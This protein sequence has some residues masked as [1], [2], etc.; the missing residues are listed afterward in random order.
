MQMSYKAESLTGRS[1]LRNKFLT[2][3]LFMLGSFLFSSFL[4]AEGW[5]SP[6]SVSDPEGKWKNEIRCTDGNTGT[7]ADDWSLRKGWG[8]F[9]VLNYNT[10]VTSDRVRVNSDWW[11]GAVDKIDLDVY[12]DGSWVNVHEGAVANC[13]WTTKTFPAGDVTKIRYRFHY[14]KSNYIYWL[15]EI[16]LYEKTPQ[17]QLT[18]NTTV[19]ATSVEPTS[20]I[21]HGILDNDG[22]EPSEYRFVYGT[23]TNY[24]QST[25]WNGPWS[26]GQVFGHIISGLSDETEYHF[27]IQTRNSVGTSAGADMT[28][29][30]GEPVIGWVPPTNYSDPSG[31][32][33]NE[34]NGFDDMQGS[35]ARCYHD[36]WTDQW[37]P[38][39]ILT[40]PELKTTGIRFMA[41]H[42]EFIDQIDVD[43][44]KDGAW[45]GVYTG[46]FGDRQWVE[47][48]FSAGMV[49]QARVR[50]HVTGTNCG[51]Y[52][53]LVEFD[54]LYN[55]AP[56][57]VNETAETD[58]ETEITV[59]VLEND[60]DADGHTIVLSQIVDPAH[61]TATFS[62]DS[63]TY[64]PQASFMGTDT[65]T[66]TVTDQLGAST[67]GTLTIKTGIDDDIYEENDIQA[68]A[69]DLSS[70]ITENSF[71]IEN[72]AV[73]PSDEDWY[74]IQTTADAGLILECLFTYRNDGRDDSDLDLAVFSQDGSVI[75]QSYS[76]T[77][78]EKVA[79]YA[80]AGQPLFIRVLG[81]DN[82][83][84][85]GSGPSWNTYSL[86]LS[87]LPSE[88]IYEQND[89]F[90]AAADITGKLTAGSF[91]SGGLFCGPSDDDWFKVQVTESVT[92][93]INTLFAER[94]DGYDDSDIDL[95]VYNSSYQLLG[96]S[97]SAT[98]NE[99]VEI[100]LTAADTVYVRIYG[101]D[102]TEYGGSKSWN[103][104]TLEVKVQYANTA[105]VADSKNVTTDEDTSAVITLSGT[106]AENDPLTFFVLTQPAHG[107]L[108]GTAPSLT[109]TPAANYNGSDSFTYKVNDGTVDSNTAALSITV[110]PVNDAPTALDDSVSTPLNTAVTVDVLANDTD[111]DGD[112]LSIQSV[113]Q[114]ANG[115]ASTDGANVTFTPATNI[116]GTETITCTITDGKGETAASTL[117]VTVFLQDDAYE[118]NDIQETAADVSSLILNNAFT[119]ENLAV[120][121]SDEDWFKIQTADNTGFIL[122]CLFTQRNDG[123]DDSDLDLAVFAEDGTVIVESYSGSDNEKVAFYTTANQPVFVRVL[124]YDNSEWGGAGPSW[125]TYSL[126]LSE[127]PADDT[128]EENDSFG[129]AK[130][131]TSEMTGGSFDSGVLFCGPSE[132]DWFSA[133]VTEPATVTVNCIFAERGDEYDDS[134]ID[135]EV[136]NSSH[137]LIASSLS[138]TD[139]ESVEF[140]LT[141]ADTIYVKIYGADNTEYGGSKSWNTYT[142]EININYGNTAPVAD[143]ITIT[144]DEDTAAALT[145]SGSDAE[146]DPLTFEVVTQPANGT[147][148]GTAPSLTYTPAANTNGADSFTYRAYDGAQYSAPATVSITVNAVNDAPFGDDLTITLDEDTSA[149]VTLAGTDIDNDPMTYVIVTE[150]QQGTLS[151]TAPE[152]TYTP[153][154]DANGT[155]SFTYK[156]N[157]GS[158]D[159]NT[160]SV[161]IT[162]TPVNDNPAA[163]DDT[164]ST[165]EDVAVTIDVL[166]NDSDA[167]NDTLSVQS[168]TQPVNGT[169][170]NNSTNVSYTPG[171]GFSG[172]DTFT[173]TVSDGNGGTAT[174][175]VS[176]TVND[177]NEAP[178]AQDQTLSTDE[179][180]A[181]TI[182]LS[183]TD[184]D[185]D[186]LTYTVLSNPANGTLSGT[187]PNLTFT[188]AADWS[189]STSFTFKANDGTVDSD[190]AT[191]SIT[192]TAVND[193]PVANGDT[194][195]TDED[196][197]ASFD[198]LANDVDV[199][200]NTL[201]LASL[202]NPPSNGVAA[203][204]AD[205]TRVEYTP[206]ADYYGSD[207]VTYTVSDG[208]GNSNTA[209][210][211]VTVNAVND[212]PVADS[213]DLT[214]DEDTALAV[215]LTASDPDDDTLTFTVL[216]D[217]E[218]G[219]LTGTAPNLT[220]TP[221]ADWNGETSF[222]FKANDGTENS[223][224]ATVTLT[225]TPLQDA[226]VA[227]DDTATT[228]EDTAATISVLANDSDADNDTLS[229]QSV[230]QGSNGTVTNNETDVT[231][232]PNENWSGTDTFTYTASDGNN[233]TDTATVSV[234]VIEQ[235]GA[236]IA[237]AQS[238]TLSEDSETPVDI[239]LTGSDPDGDDITFAIVDAPSHGTLTG[240]A[241]NLTYMPDENYSGTDSFTFKV[242]DGTEDSN[243]VTVSIDVTPINDAPVSCNSSEEVI[244]NKPT[245]ITVSAEDADNDELT[246]VITDQPGH[247]ILTG[248]GP[249]YTYTPDLGY[250]GPD[251]FSFK[252]NDGTED[253]SEAVVSIDVFSLYIVSIQTE[254][255]LLTNKEAV[256]VS[257]TLDTEVVRIEARNETINSKPCI[258]ALH[259]DQSFEVVNIPVEAGVNT[260]RLTTFNENGEENGTTIVNVK[261]DQ[262]PPV[263][264][265]PSYETNNPWAIV[266][267]DNTLCNVIVQTGDAT[268]AP[269]RILIEDAEEIDSDSFYASYYVRNQETGEIIVEPTDLT[270]L[271]DV[272]GGHAEFQ[273]DDGILDNFVTRYLGHE[274]VFEYFASDRA[275]NWGV[276]VASYYPGYE[277]ENFTGLSLDIDNQ[278]AFTL[279]H[280][281]TDDSKGTRLV[282]YASVD[283]AEF[284]SLGNDNWELRGTLSVYVESPIGLK[285][286]ELSIDVSSCGDKANTIT[287]QF[288]GDEQ[289]FF[290]NS[291]YS[292]TKSTLITTDVSYVFNCPVIYPGNDQILD[293]FGINL[294]TNNLYNCTSTLDLKLKITNGNVVYHTFY[295]GFYFDPSQN[296]DYYPPSLFSP[297]DFPEALID[298]F[299][300]RIETYIN[301]SCAGVAYHMGPVIANLQCSVNGQPN[302]MV[303]V[304][305]SVPPEI[306]FYKGNKPSGFPAA[307]AGDYDYYF[308]LNVPFH[309]ADGSY[310]EDDLEFETYGYPPDITWQIIEPFSTNDQNREWYW[311]A[312]YSGFLHDDGKSLVNSYFG[313]YIFNEFKFHDYSIVVNINETKDTVLQAA[314]WVVD[315]EIISERSSN[316]FFDAVCSQVDPTYYNVS[317]TGVRPGIEELIAS[318][319][320]ATGQN[321]EVLVKGVDF[322]SGIPIYRNA[323]IYL[324]TDTGDVLG[325]INPSTYSP[326]PVS[327]KG[328]VFDPV[329]GLSIE[330]KIF[331]DGIQHELNEITGGVYS[332]DIP[333]EVFDGKE[334]IIISYVNSSG[335]TCVLTVDLLF[336]RGNPENKQAGGI[337]VRC[338][339]KI[340]SSTLNQN[341]IGGWKNYR[342][343][344][345][346]PS[347]IIIRNETENSWGN[348]EVSAASEIDFTQG[349]FVVDDI[350]FAV[351]DP[352]INRLDN[353]VATGNPVI[354]GRVGDLISATCD[355][356]TTY[357][358]VRGVDFYEEDIEL[359]VKSVANQVEHDD[360]QSQGYDTSRV[361]VEFVFC[362]KN[363]SSIVCTPPPYYT[364]CL[365]LISEPSDLPEDALWQ[366]Y[367]ASYENTL[368]L[369]ED[370]APS[371]PTNGFIKIYRVYYAH[372]VLPYQYD[373]FYDNYPVKVYDGESD[374]PEFESP[375][376]VSP[377]QG[378]ASPGLDNGAFS[379][380]FNSAP[381]YLHNGAL[382]LGSNDM[383]TSSAKGFGLNI[384][385][386][387]RSHNT[388]Q[389]EFGYGWSLGYN[390]RLELI[391]GEGERQIAF[392]DGT[393]KFHIFTETDDKWTS[394]PGLYLRL[395]AEDDNTFKLIDGGG[396]EY[397]FTP[398]PDR[399]YL[400]TN[401]CD[402][403]GNMLTI[404]YKKKGADFIV[405]EVTDTFGRKLTFEGSPVITRITGPTGRYLEYDYFEIDDDRLLKK[406]TLFSASEEQLSTISYY[407]NNSETAPPDELTAL[408]M[409]KS[410]DNIYW[411]Y[412]YA[413]GKVEDIKVSD[414]PDGS[415]TVYKANTFDYSGPVSY[416]DARNN[417]WQYTINGNIAS[418]VKDPAGNITQ[419]TYTANLE[420]DE[421]TYPLG[422]KTKYYYSTQIEDPDNPGTMIDNPNPVKC[423]N[424]VKV[425][426]TPDSTRGTGGSSETI[427]TTTAYTAAADFPDADADAAE[428]WNFVKSSTDARGY[429]TYNYYNKDGNLIRT[430][431]N[432]ITL[433]DGTKQN[434]VTKYKYNDYGQLLATL[435]A[436]GS[437]SWNEYYDSSDAIGDYADCEG[438]LRRTVQSVGRSYTNINTSAPGNPRNSEDYVVT[439]Y[440]WDSRGN[441]ITQT[442]PKG[443]SWITHYDELS[444]VTDEYSPPWANGERNHTHYDYG[445]TGN[446]ETKTVKIWTPDDQNST[447]YSAQTITTTMTYDP[448]DRLL[449]TTRGDR[450]TTRTYYADGS[451]KS[452]RDPEGVYTTYTYNNR[453]LQE[454][455]ISRDTDNDPATVPTD[456]I[457]S[458]SEFDANGNL[459]D[460][461]ENTTHIEHRDYDGYDRVIKTTDKE[462]DTY[463]ETTFDNNGNVLTTV[464]KKGSDTLSSMAYTYNELND[465]L[466]SKDL[467][468]NST[469]TTDTYYTQAKTAVIDPSGKKTESFVDGLGRTVK[470]VYA[471]G[472]KVVTVYDKNGAV[473]STST[474]EIGAS[475]EV[476]GDGWHTTTFERNA[477]DH[478]TSAT[479]AEGN[480]TRAAT[481][482]FG[483][484]V[485][486]TGPDNKIV[487]KEFNIHGEATA[488][489][490]GYG[491]SDQTT[492]TTVYNKNSQVKSVTQGGQSTTY[493]YANNML[494]RE[495]YPDNTSIEYEYDSRDFLTKKILKDGTYF[496]YDY[497]PATKYLTQIRY[498]NGADTYVARSFSNFDGFGRA[499]TITEYNNPNRSDDD[500]STTRVF[501]S[502]GQVT[503]ESTTVWGQTNTVSRQF[504]ESG[505]MTQITYPSGPVYTYQYTDTHELAK[506][507][508]GQTDILDYEHKGL[509]LISGMK[510]NSDKVNLKFNYDKN[511]A[512]AGAGAI[513]DL[514]N[515]DTYDIGITR[516][517]TG[518]KET[519]TRFGLTDTFDYDSKNRHNV[520]HT[521]RPEIGSD[522]FKLDDVDNLEA[523]VAWLFNGENVQHHFGLANRL[524]QV[525]FPDAPDKTFTLTY[526]GRGNTTED[527]N[528][529]YFWDCFDRVR[530]IE[531]K[532]TTYKHTPLTPI[533]INTTSDDDSTTYE[534]SWT[535]EA[536]V[537][538]VEFE[539]TD[540]AAYEV[541]YLDNENELWIKLTATAINVEGFVHTVDFPGVQTDKIRIIEQNPNPSMTDIKTGFGAWTAWR[542]VQY[543][544]DALGRRV[545]R[546]QGETSDKMLYVYNGYQVI[547]QKNNANTLKKRIVYGAGINEPVMLEIDNS[548]QG[549]DGIYYYQLDDLNSCYVLVDQNGQIVEQY[550]YSST[551]QTVIQEPDGTIK[552]YDHDGETST[553]EVHTVTSDFGNPFMFTSMWR[554]D[555]TGIY[556]THYRE[557]NPAIGRWLT[558][559]PAGYVDGMNLY[560]YY[561]G[562]NG[563]DVLGLAEIMKG[564]WGSLPRTWGE[565]WRNLKEEREKVNKDIRSL[566]GGIG[567]GAKGAVDVVAKTPGAVKYAAKFYY[568]R[569][570][571]GAKEVII[572][573]PEVAKM[574]GKGIA[575]QV[576][577]AA[578]GDPEAIGELLFTAETLL[579][580]Q[581]LSAA[582][583][584]SYSGAIR[585]VSS[586]GK[587]AAVG[588]E[589]LAAGTQ[590][591]I[592]I[593][594][595]VIKAVAVAG[596]GTM[597]TAGTGSGMN[598]MMKGKPGGTNQPI[599]FSDRISTTKL[600]GKSYTSGAKKLRKLGL[601]ERVT[602]TGRREFFDAKKRVRAAWDAKRK[603]VGGSHWHKFA[604][605]GRT[606]LN[607]A[608]HVVL[609][610]MPKAHIPSK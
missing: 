278:N 164:A 107:T 151:G 307:V 260:V 249:V 363:G 572:V 98:D 336:E 149:G 95:E 405:S 346:S 64:T 79:F 81:Y 220:F 506:I 55:H 183:A 46:P 426:Q 156:V 407:Y 586:G 245:D 56:T 584:G 41:K 62:G 188:P 518:L 166:A 147:L 348:D 150:P 105:P 342:S 191:V 362:E 33:E 578:S 402:R 437:M 8:A 163:N 345:D 377:R 427:V 214:T 290:N 466:T 583:L 472:T 251:F 219:T 404:K 228:N 216:T 309:C 205:K 530:R 592:T 313:I 102:N 499:R 528:F 330:R 599:K 174:A 196:T 4:H 193:A 332:F 574:M 217:P 500:T 246:Y 7:Y 448:L 497:D 160:A 142:L 361:Y 498:H 556:H 169:V 483:R 580:G 177:T 24:G 315:E 552:Y 176:V 331:I 269:L 373:I 435:N 325:V 187:A 492:T 152:L 134:D 72:L 316:G 195:S 289:I 97:L 380:S 371:E 284:V 154:P 208:I 170:T 303:E 450:V 512:L 386:T 444:R 305:G 241:P 233:G 158:E 383:S 522:N 306:C 18:Q 422:N 237:D 487:H 479:D 5:K 110:T 569:G 39:L 125:N 130:N 401:I 21:L 15:Y 22:G 143:A 133:D 238:V 145:L 558:P 30:T 489:T 40:R 70:E 328:K 544:Y 571:K 394:P 575:Q 285:S 314:E 155:D 138:A 570:L 493:V 178:V 32:W 185:N 605:D 104:Y 504:S 281:T 419:Y 148:S 423:G 136:Y 47:K 227:A 123:R 545:A 280:Q 567:K 480:T 173:Y 304:C 446:L 10:P 231:Y 610:K 93:T 469:T 573:A 117:S 88:D 378:L 447:T 14:L 44:Y 390:Q 92:V 541:W 298:E 352:D 279:S 203:I 137:Q 194:V 52:W 389:L 171:T 343:A 200:N 77:E 470:T 259:G 582:N 579:A 593:E 461:Y 222:T 329:F 576:K 349:E 106:D 359:K 588:G 344:D 73:R 250:V 442:D 481:D 397:R 266:S 165:D 474:A 587:L 264:T 157:D 604:P 80:T 13:S 502:F 57:V 534:L 549:I 603:S 255:S 459:T 118:E 49:S 412:T 608:G 27:Q 568:K 443:R 425:I 562:V 590:V 526:D 273:P 54:F 116:L 602:K 408:K 45:E 333:V 463:T 414:T 508:S 395:L 112:T 496:L 122:E 258:G 235:Q 100:D 96:S 159:S 144:T 555:I 452:V 488:V 531:N 475:S 12:K 600:K 319:L 324:T 121:P 201:Q 393:G 327:I 431:A 398:V 441:L 153:L 296:I 554:D 597:I 226:P 71:T 232:T 606:P 29:T 209:T 557:Y 254:P 577:A 424:V 511:G 190:P 400:L 247:G 275:G 609:K 591:I 318:S 455:I 438:Y 589:T 175:T 485:F 538:F 206:N 270:Y 413:D 376:G 109:Y 146:N 221:D 242:N 537:N 559:D 335:R 564:D 78:N 124:G 213:Q 111:V 36:L 467:L 168:V 103:N 240:T 379:S 581:G 244:I 236:P 59:N 382:V 60:S 63:I 282:S 514:I 439:D 517:S 476:G 262:T 86:V 268:I 215:T 120:R 140:E 532:N 229:I 263:L 368:P 510:L 252:V 409:I 340:S 34:L 550:D 199:E 468:K 432:N 350:V 101:A 433:S 89:S 127:L 317:I 3:T 381:V 35:H 355:T 566:F 462:T 546:T 374:G 454:K 126:V 501:N 90:S 202:P 181:L 76:G 61:G 457:V 351:V 565:L 322:T 253:S 482:G 311:N 28:F 418:S 180:T 372:T 321:V 598:M 223:N 114:P 384:S 440:A 536:V 85:G 312:G 248:D 434:I 301:E 113:T 25:P 406:V 533:A 243:A 521:T 310:L 197:T 224:T 326:K 84:W 417:V 445:N 364:R 341:T 513:E 421:I 477:L 182:T 135:L 38:Y 503:S 302:E 428:Y 69:A 524:T 399:R 507:Q 360:A 68:D 239:V 515:G 82:S 542:S 369:G 20:A 58:L 288:E 370:G 561:A 478:V 65:I 6:D 548:G 211:S 525:E 50:F 119:I 495:E 198:V 385:R 294:T 23:D 1:I 271:F 516:K 464:T 19:A 560:R 436:D 505:D 189:G 291:P 283:N 141:E 2:L 460:S 416:T 210:V 66:Y 410:P 16:Q 509:G 132:A 26:N 256:N 358:C 192:V 129:A 67:D 99:N 607:D 539:Y 207:S 357:S 277:Y 295:G 484:N 523:G 595:G 115:S 11:T 167:D 529:R 272:N 43:V 411:I 299:L 31:K 37:G 265:T 553:P 519:V 161:S 218:N 429:T 403:Y 48:H 184:N 42:G 108:S 527:K 451:L 128:Y 392:H 300:D 347:E 162:I 388:R 287:G 261:C 596:K 320:W 453:G 465:Q 276:A 139:N 297:S 131:I 354:R 420:Y 396:T 293:F 520:T 456:A 51:L 601:K 547:E 585:I 375:T 494:K 75:V 367:G 473:I 234:T 308:T 179:D 540:T 94:S 563:V 212:T 323:K 339:D 186:T 491:S 458:R 353:F 230:T 338:G 274:F 387:Y 490:R 391:P 486:T 594:A 471:D 172:T 74:K 535:P 267:V 449:T 356:S 334:N 551:G 257:G 204:S 430:E 292:I 365:P 91:T 83:E 543:Y 9:I 87:P 286:I 415:G 53:E 225:V 17:V 366:Y 337:I